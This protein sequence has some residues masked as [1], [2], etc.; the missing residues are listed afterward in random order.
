MKHKLGN[1]FISKEKKIFVRKQIYTNTVKMFRKSSQ[2]I[3]EHVCQGI[4]MLRSY[5]YISAFLCNVEVTFRH[6]KTFL[7]HDPL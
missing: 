1:K 5:Y 6:G 3:S 4:R 7:K 2:F